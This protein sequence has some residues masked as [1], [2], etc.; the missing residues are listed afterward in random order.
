MSENNSNHLEQFSPKIPL[1][2]FCI[3]FVPIFVSWFMLSHYNVFELSKTGPAALTPIGIFGLLLVVGFSILW[4]ITQTKRIMNFDANSAESVAYTN[5]VAKRFLSIT[6]YT[7]ILNG[8]VVPA[9][10]LNSFAAI[11][12]TPDAA[13][14]FIGCLGNVL[15]YSLLFYILFMQSFISLQ[16]SESYETN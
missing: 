15:L 3:Y 1:F 16:K 14:L 7:G 2:Y 5:K 11:G 6:M 12:Y 10:V 9:V 4:Y 13:P 8:I